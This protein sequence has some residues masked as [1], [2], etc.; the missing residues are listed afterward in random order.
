MATV[1]QGGD[2]SLSP[3]HSQHHHQHN[4]N[5]NNH[6]KK[7]NSKK[8]LLLLIMG[9]TVGGLG[10]LAHR[11][12]LQFRHRHEDVTL[13][14]LEGLGMKLEENLRNVILLLVVLLSV[15]L[16]GTFG[17]SPPCYLIETMDG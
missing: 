3:S 13:D 12:R 11:L 9:L 5:N 14:G 17:L 8:G 4:H 16:L 7:G 15:C 1:A 6:Q 10:I 2:L